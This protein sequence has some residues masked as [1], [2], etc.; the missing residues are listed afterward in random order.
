MQCT[1][2]Y[3][4]IGDH[5]HSNTNHLCPAHLDIKTI[6]IIVDMLRTDCKPDW[7]ISVPPVYKPVSRFVIHLACF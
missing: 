5:A 7:L 4:Y 1:S 3:L 6:T 2:L